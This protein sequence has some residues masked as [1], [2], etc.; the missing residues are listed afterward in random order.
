M[1]PDNPED[2]NR[3]GLH[4]RFKVCTGVCYLGVFIRNDKSKHYWQK[5]C[6]LIWEWKICTI[7]ETDRK[8]PQESY[9]DVVCAI[10]LDPIFLNTSWG[11]QDMNSQA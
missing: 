3:F 1:H 11:I 5:F 4:Q 9:T 10:Q 6:P 8:Y 2:M 7:R